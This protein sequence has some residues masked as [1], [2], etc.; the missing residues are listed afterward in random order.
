MALALYLGI[1]LTVIGMPAPSGNFLGNPLIGKGPL[2]RVWTALE[3]FGRYTAKLLVPLDLSVDYGFASIGVA[4]SPLAPGVLGSLLAGGAPISRS[5]AWR[6]PG[7]RC[8][9]DGGRTHPEH[10]T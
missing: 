9:R 1:R 10:A 3:L 4:S 5:G 7:R 6:R 8:S 2:V